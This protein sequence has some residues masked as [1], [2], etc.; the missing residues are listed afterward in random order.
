MV[1]M[2]RISTDAIIERIDN[3]RVY[4]E[5]RF[6]AIE[7]HLR[8]LNSQVEKNTAFRIKFNG[9]TKILGVIFGSGF[10]GFLV[11]KIFGLV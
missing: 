4:M 6:N 9:A 5:E 2:A 3:L 11:L 7:E 10:F 1:K 8:K